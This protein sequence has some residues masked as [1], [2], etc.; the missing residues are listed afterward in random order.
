MEHVTGLGWLVW[1]FTVSADQA[2]VELQD[3][4]L[5]GTSPPRP[6]QEPVDAAA[7]CVIL[8]FIGL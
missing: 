4:L 3:R 1:C 7:F 2:G 5:K 8:L 6:V